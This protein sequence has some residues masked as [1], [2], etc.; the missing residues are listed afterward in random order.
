MNNEGTLFEND[1]VADVF[2]SHY[3][4]FLGE[5]GHTSGFD[6]EDLFQSRIADQD[7][8]NMVRPISRQEV[9][10]SMF[11]MGYDK[12]LGPDGYSDAFFKK[13]W[14]V[15]EKDVIDAIF[16]I[17]RPP[18]NPKMGSFHSKEDDVSKISTSIFVTNFPDSFSAKD[19][20]HSCKQYGHGHSFIPTKRTKDVIGKS[21]VSVVK[22]SR[23]PIDKESP[24]AIVL[25]DDYLNAKDLTLSLMGKVKEMTSLVN[26]KKALCN[27]GFDVLRLATWENF[28]YYSNRDAKTK[29]SFRGPTSIRIA[30]KWVLETLFD[31]P[32]DQKDKYSEDPFGLY[33]L[34]N[35]ENI[36]LEQ[37]VTE[38]DHS[39]SHP[40]GFTPEEGLNE[41]N[42][43]N[44]DMKDYGENERDDN[45]FVNLEDGKDNSKCVLKSRIDLDD[46]GCICASRAKEKR[47]LWDYMAHGVDQ[48]VGFLERGPVTKTWPSENFMGKLKETLSK[49]RIRAGSLFIGRIREVNNIQASEI[50]QKAKIKWA[51]EGDENVKFFHG[52]LN[53]KRN[54]SNIRG[55]MVNGTWVDDPVQVKREF[56][57]HFRG[58]FDRE[59][60]QEYCKIFGE[61]ISGVLVIFQ[62]VQSAF[63]ADRQILNG[64]FILDEVLQWCRRKKKHALIFKVDFEKA[65]DSVRWDFVDDVLNKFG[66]G[67][68]WRTWI[69]S[70]W[71]K[72]GQGSKLGKEWWTMWLSHLSDED[73]TLLI[74]ARLTLLKSCLRSMPI[75]ISI[76]KVPQLHPFEA[77][78]WGETTEFFLGRLLYEAVSSKSCSLYNSLSKKSEKGIEEIQLNSC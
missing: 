62:E 41:G 17:N 73:E 15:V 5:A 3:V 59:L 45:S 12:S 27:E 50:A 30:A 72:Y 6:G 46:S 35:K 38:E 47:M 24:P 39:L 36:E 18:F 75:S 2:V 21:F 26:L 43:V 71:G 70:C 74:E 13:A 76:F 37:K 40:P 9:K 58:S 31:Q 66:F 78:E 69:Q 20:F 49:D 52:M 60:I 44:L 19:L 22:T 77:G 61:P 14:H 55:I 67:E 56:F 54:Q 25:E 8:L 33:P 1:H 53:K 7:A 34:L 64:P 42:T 29:D 28:W 51:I 10:D 23:M 48:W 11:A 16:S 4:N 68:R 57:E 65:F 63:V 32:D